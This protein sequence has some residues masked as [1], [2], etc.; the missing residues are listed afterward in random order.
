MGGHGNT[1]TVVPEHQ[2]N[3]YNPLGYREAYPD[4]HATGAVGLCSWNLTW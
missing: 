2:F 4:T 3:F 1:G